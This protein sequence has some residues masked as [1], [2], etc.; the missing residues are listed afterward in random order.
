MTSFYPLDAMDRGSEAQLQVG[1][2]NQ[3]VNDT[4]A[5]P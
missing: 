3:S 4:K 2:T 5:H 1:E